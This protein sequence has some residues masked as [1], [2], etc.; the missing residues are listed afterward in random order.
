MRAWTEEGERREKRGPRSTRSREGS[1]GTSAGELRL[2]RRESKLRGFW[3]P[4]G[5]AVE[6][7]MEVLP[8]G[9]AGWEREESS[10][11]SRDLE[12]KPM[13]SG[14]EF[15]RCRLPS[16]SPSSSMEECR[17]PLGEVGGVIRF[18][19]KKNGVQSKKNKE[20]PPRRTKELFFFF[21]KNR[22]KMKKEL[23]NHWVGSAD[24]VAFFWISIFEI[25][26]GQR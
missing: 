22:K 9:T 14:C 2:R 7:P 26:S 12:G 4:K 10:A 17:P 16:P 13:G 11:G 8:L 19:N 3:P 5:R 21:E 18:I 24:V 6:E 20:N 25:V 15:V 23:T 1:V